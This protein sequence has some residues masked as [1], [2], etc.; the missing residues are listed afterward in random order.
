MPDNLPLVVVILSSDLLKLRHLT[1]H[2]Q[3]LSGKRYIEGLI[4]FFQ[5][6]KEVYKV[7]ESVRNRLRKRHRGTDDFI[8]Y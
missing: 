3:R 7:V 6:E 8:G 2:Q 1:L 5:K 4:V